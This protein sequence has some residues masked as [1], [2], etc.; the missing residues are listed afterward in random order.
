MFFLFLGTVFS[1]FG[2]LM[3][4]FN[5]QIIRHGE[6]LEGY[7]IGY[8]SRK[9]SSHRGTSGSTDAPIVEFEYDGERLQIPS[10]MS[11]AWHGFKVGDE[12]T[13]Y[14]DP[15][16]KSEVILD[17]FYHKYGFGIFF[18]LCGILQFIILWFTGKKEK[19]Q[20]KGAA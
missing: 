3:L 6:V 8:E 19:P 13:F 20:K 11:S 14:F 16:D 9:Q 4:Y 15:A 12:V 7:V 1:L 18:A 2:A 10:Q 17:S 5:L